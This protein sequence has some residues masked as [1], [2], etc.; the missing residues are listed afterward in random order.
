MK[1]RFQWVMDYLVSCK[2]WCYLIWFINSTWMNSLC[3]IKDRD[4]ISIWIKISLSLSN[5]ME[6]RT[7]PPHQQLPT[8]IRFLQPPGKEGLQLDPLLRRWRGECV[9]L[10]RWFGVR[11][12]QWSLRLARRIQPWRMHPQRRSHRSGWWFQMP[13]PEAVL[14]W[15]QWRISPALPPPHFLPEILHLHE[16][17]VPTWAELPHWSR[18]QPRDQSL[19]RPGTHPQLVNRSKSN[20]KL[21][22][23]WLLL[24]WH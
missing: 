12:P 14:P 2:F 23:K 9:H 8:K 24:I 3:W 22:S 18:L 13:R 15:W 20:W 16:R 7:C 1:I 19:W 17:V 4:E 6:W 21:S 5:L 11:S 10:P